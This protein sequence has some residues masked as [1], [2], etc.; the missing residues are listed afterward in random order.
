PRDWV[1]VNN[2]DEPARPLALPLPPGQAVHLRHDMR[3]LP[4]KVAQ[5]LPRAMQYQGFNQEKERLQRECN[6]R[7]DELFAELRALAA[8]R[9]LHVEVSPEGNLVFAPLRD[10]QPMTQEEIG[11]MSPE[12]VGAFIEKPMA[13]LREAQSIFER[14]QAALQQMHQTIQ[15]IER[16]LADALLTSLV[17][18][19]WKKYAVQ[20]V[21]DWLDR[22]KQHILDN[23]AAFFPAPPPSENNPEGPP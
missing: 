5:L 23:L 8:E 18:P 14:Q 9:E 20:P 15:N 12:E 10:L 22:V 7:C 2:F 6:Q 1:F 3:G 21:R 19:L 4:L 11:Q 16:T 13:V 17:D